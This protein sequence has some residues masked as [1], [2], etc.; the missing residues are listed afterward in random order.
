MAKYIVK[1]IFYMA[2]VLFIVTTITFFLIHAIPG[3]PILAM[4]SEMPE[5]NRATYLQ[6]YGYDQPVSIQY[7]KFIKELLQG[8]LGDS[9]RY[10]GRAVQGIVVKYAPVSAVIGGVGLLLGFV[11]GI[12]LGIIAALNRNKPI[13]KIIIILALLGTTIPAFVIASLLQYI[14]SVK[15]K[16]LPTTGWKGVK[17]AIL[18]VACMFVN[19]LATYAR[20]MR[21]SMLDVGSQDYILVAQAKGV[22]RF[23]I[24]TR[25]MLRNAFLPCITLLGVNVANIFSGSFIIETLFAIPGVGRYFISAINDRDYSMVL[26]LNIIFT[27]IYILSI[28]I[29]DI[30]LCILD[31]RI[32]LTNDKKHKRPRQVR[33]A[34]ERTQVAG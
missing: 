22:S 18:P 25:H 12:V 8:N 7:L 19:P 24:V 30:F 23:G 32:R 29:T 11:L 1:R 15:L 10:P 5:A 31:P 3:D 26:G 17:Y 21:S 13:D 4:V 27:G 9:V 6:K 28:L 20:Y 34:S 33:K 14:F 2:L 16:L